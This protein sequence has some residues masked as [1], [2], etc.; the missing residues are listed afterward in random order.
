MR[1][2][3]PFAMPNINP[4]PERNFITQKKIRKVMLNVRIPKIRTQ[5]IIIEVRINPMI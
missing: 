2:K 1:S 4:K 5:S 3:N